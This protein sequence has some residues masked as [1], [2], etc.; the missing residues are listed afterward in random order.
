MSRFLGSGW[1]AIFVA[2]GDESGWGGPQNGPPVYHHGADREVCQ[3]CGVGEL[4][5]EVIT[6]GRPDR[7]G[8]VEQAREW[9]RRKNQVRGWLSGV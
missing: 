9:R 4:L 6:A 3:K 8:G 5:G 7:P 2:F 1:L